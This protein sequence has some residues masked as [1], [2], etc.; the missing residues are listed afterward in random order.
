MTTLT[1][2]CI[3]DKADELN[4]TFNAGHII[5][6]HTWSH[7]DITKL[8]ASQLNQELEKV[9][10]ALKKILGIKPKLFRPPYGNYDDDALE[11]LAQR[12]YSS[13]F[14]RLTCH[15]KAS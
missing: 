2:D 3:Y 15:E 4:D 10:V 1:D 11:V 5:G 8:S 6:S 12:G 14:S 9:E 7:A 13:E